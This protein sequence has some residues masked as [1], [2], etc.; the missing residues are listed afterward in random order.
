MRSANFCIVSILVCYIQFSYAILNGDGG[1]DISGFTSFPD[2]PQFGETLNSATQDSMPTP[3]PTSTPSS[4]SAPIPTATPSSSSTP[5]SPPPPM[6][7]AQVPDMFSGILDNFPGF[8]QFS[9]IFGGASEPEAPIPAGESTIPSPSPSLSLSPP[10]GPSPPPGEQSPPPPMS[11]PPPLD[12][13]APAEDS[14]STTNGLSSNLGS[15]SNFLQNGIGGSFSNGLGGGFS[16]LFGGLSTPTQT[17]TP[18]PA[19]PGCAPQ[20][21][22]EPVPAPEPEVT[23]EVNEAGADRHT[24]GNP[25]ATTVSKAKPSSVLTSSDIKKLNQIV[26]SCLNPPKQNKAFVKRSGNRFTKSGADFSFVGFNAYQTVS[27]VLRGQTYAV[28]EL[29]ENARRVGMN[30]GRLWAFSDDIRTG[31][32]Q[33]STDSFKALDR[34][35]KIARDNGVHLV[36]GLTNYWPEYTSPELY[37]YWAYGSIQGRTVYHFYTDPNVKLLFKAHMCKV[38]KRVNSITRARYRNDPTIL[39]WNLIN[40]PRCPGCQTKHIHRWIKEMAGYLQKIDPHHLVTVGM[41]GFHAPFS[42]INGANPGVWALCQGIDFTGG[43][44]QT[45]IDYM[46]AHIYPSYK[47]WD[48]ENNRACD[49]DCQFDW[50]QYALQKHIQR[51]TSYNRPFVLEEFGVSVKL[52]YTN[53]NNGQT[54]YTAADR[55]DYYKRLLGVLVSASNRRDSGSGGL[56]WTAATGGYADYD[57][58]TVNLDDNSIVPYSVGLPISSAENDRFRRKSQQDSCVQ[59]YQNEGWRPDV[60]VTQPIITL[61]GSRPVDVINSAAANI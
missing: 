6:S 23:G 19:G 20:P 33:W 9:S 32:L 3:T 49:K 27:Q 25:V 41:E 60:V 46:S 45:G 61:G 56:F 10:I 59:R 44:R 58:Y 13:S 7:Q 26:N 1:L 21:E 36:L 11:P 43:H 4:T 18:T 40:E 14:P 48:W 28:R 57:G 37:I 12:C 24:R 17:S 38:V 30:V 54:R 50:A 5:G 51:A 55:V 47:G 53:T 52:T 31:P 39:G 34:V 35:I 16:D 15:F 2:L 8:N 42:S 29:M 22:A